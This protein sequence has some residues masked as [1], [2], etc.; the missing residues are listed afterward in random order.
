MGSHANNE[1][2]SPRI[3]RLFRTRYIH[4]RKQAALLCLDTHCPRKN[5]SINTERCTQEDLCSIIETCTQINDNVHKKLTWHSSRDSLLHVSDL[6]SGRE[7]LYPPYQVYKVLSRL[8]LG[9][10]LHTSTVLLVECSFEYS[11]AALFPFTL[12]IFITS[13]AHVRITLHTNQVYKGAA[14]S[15]ME[16]AEVEFLAE[17]ELVTIVPNFSENKLYLIS[18]W[19]LLYKCIYTVKCVMITSHPPR[20]NLVHSTPQCRPKF[21]YGWPSI[22]DRDRNV[23]LSLQTGSMLVRITHHINTS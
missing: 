20:G 6:W 16:P 23:T 1:I 3:T 17:K 9:F 10:Q 8:G 7:L 14:H 21:P 5:A 15:R 12:R 11:A 22:Y 13:S 19:D 2:P 18:V 4:I